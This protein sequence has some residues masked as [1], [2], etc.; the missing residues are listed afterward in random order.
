MRGGWFLYWDYQI[1]Y[2]ITV[3]ADGGAVPAKTFLWGKV[4]F[5]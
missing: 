4:D 1:R 2:S 3:S 5:P